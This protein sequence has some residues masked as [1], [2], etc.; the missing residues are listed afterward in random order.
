LRNSP[1]RASA[2][3]RTSASAAA[4]VDGAHVVRVATCEVAR[5]QPQRSQAAPE[6]RPDQHPQQRHHEQHGRDQA[7][8]EVVDE[9]LAQAEAVADHHAN[10]FAGVLHR[11]DTP[12]LAVDLALREA[13][14]RIRQAP[15][16]GP[17]RPRDHA[18]VERPDLT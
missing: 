1:S 8:D 2:R 11:E 12:S 18:P 13:G 15:L 6:A 4:R 9:A 7:H 16:R 5:H 10:A 3:G 17:G 14:G